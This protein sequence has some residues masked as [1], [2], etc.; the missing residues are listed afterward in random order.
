MVDET[1]I[2]R[3]RNTSGNY[4]A[5]ANEDQQD[6]LEGYKSPEIGTDAYDIKKLCDQSFFGRW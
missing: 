1:P 3:C 5:S 4:L 6:P 2:Y